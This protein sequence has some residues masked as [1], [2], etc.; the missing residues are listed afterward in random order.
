M[1]IELN[2]QYDIFG[3]MFQLEINIYMYGKVNAY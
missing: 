2:R 3:A 1:F